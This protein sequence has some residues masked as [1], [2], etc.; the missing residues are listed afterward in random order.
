MISTTTGSIV[1]K[2]GIYKCT[3]GHEITFVKG[4]KVPPCRE[5]GA[6]SFRLVRETK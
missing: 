1:L 4:N 2:S 3:N 5:C 6:T